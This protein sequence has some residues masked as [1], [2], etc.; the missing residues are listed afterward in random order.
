[1]KR[2]EIRQPDISNYTQSIIS[3][4]QIIY[5]LSYP[6]KI[7]LIQSVNIHFSVSKSSIRRGKGDD[8]KMGLGMTHK[9]DS[10]LVKWSLILK[11]HSSPPTNAKL[12][13]KVQTWLTVPTNFSCMLWTRPIISDEIRHPLSWSRF[14]TWSDLRATL[15]WGAT[16]PRGC[17]Y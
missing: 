15:F 3:H 10:W 1:M 13:R 5:L 12:C 9:L 16:R 6:T 4:R 14:H 17:Y 7:S 11:L 2:Y 8:D